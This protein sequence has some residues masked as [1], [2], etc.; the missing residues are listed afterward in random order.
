MGDT[1][2]DLASTADP[3]PGV[4]RPRDPRID[5]AVLEAAS[6]LLVEIGYNRVTMAAIAERAG[7]TKTALY[8]R[9]SGKA[10]LVHEA[11]FATITALPES[12]DDV[13]ADIRAMVVVARDLFASPV[14][15]AALPGLLAEMSADPP[16]AT[17]V[18]GRFAEAFGAVGRRLQRAVDTGD[19]RAD[20]DTD[21]LVEVLGGSAMLSVL[22]YPDAVRV[23][24][25]VDQ[26]TA[27]DLQGVLAG[28]DGAVRG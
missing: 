7:T 3:G 28:G 12:T 13:A 1:I 11:A 16:L 10:E 6:E 21:R 23:D 14:A 17:R 26:M 9:W 4:G 19:V 15:H 22:L 20:V 27:L 25:W 5:S 2:D 18:H 8:R 24:G